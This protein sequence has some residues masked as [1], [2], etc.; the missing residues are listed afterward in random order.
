MIDS[1]DPLAWRAVAVVFGFVI[2]VLIFIL[3]ITSEEN[4]RYRP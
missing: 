2:V 1:I 4:R 3:K